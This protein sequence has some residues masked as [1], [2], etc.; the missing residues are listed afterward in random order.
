MLWVIS[1]DIVSLQ[2]IIVNVYLV[3]VCF[4]VHK[5]EDYKGQI[6]DVSLQYFLSEIVTLALEPQSD[7]YTDC[8]EDVEAK[9]Q[10]NHMSVEVNEPLHILPEG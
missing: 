9:N 7:Q 5:L 4:C 3:V 2:E 8:D 1:I 10:L 6:H